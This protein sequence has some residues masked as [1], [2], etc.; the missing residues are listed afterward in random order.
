VYPGLKNAFA[1][2]LTPQDGPNVRARVVTPSFANPTGYTMTRAERERF[3]AG[4]SRLVIEIDIYSRL[5]YRGTGLAPL[6]AFR[7]DER[8]LLLRSFS[9]IAFPGLRVGWIIGAKDL[10]RRLAQ[11]KQYTDLHSD[12]LSQAIMLEFARSGRLEAHLQQVLEAGRARLDA[13]IAAL[14][15]VLPS[16]ARFTRPDGGMNLWVTLPPGCDSGAVL[17]KARREGVSYL[18]GRY[19]AIHGGLGE[20]FRLSFAGLSPQRIAEGLRRLQPLFEEEARLAS[21]HQQTTAE[22]AMV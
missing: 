4:E 20:S 21:R 14:E 15:Q 18:P 3:V 17:D 12:Q 19:F 7:R 2:R 11:T 5:R 9:K 10:V 22:L 1:D 16:G 6:R 13:T 8:Y